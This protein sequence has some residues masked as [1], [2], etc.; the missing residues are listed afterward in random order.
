MKNIKKT[1]LC[2]AS[3]FFCTMAVSYGQGVGNLPLNLNF[4][5][6]T[7]VPVS[8]Q[9]D[10]FIRRWT[11]LEP[12]A[13]TFSS[14]AMLTS[15]FLSETLSEQYFKDQMTIVPVDGSK[16]T[17]GKTKLIWHALDSKNFYVNL[18]RFATAYG[19]ECFQ[20]LYWV[21]TIIDCDKD[22]ENVRLA[23]GVNSAAVWFLNDAEVL[24]FVGDKDLIVDDCM[25]ARLTLKQ[26]RNILRGIV[27]NGQGMADFC[28]RFV[29]EDGKP[30]TSGYT[31]SSMMSKKK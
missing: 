2:L 30:V 22:I 25:S 19:K 21:V 11:L 1:L 4:E 17:Y 8:P 6:A 31:V 26:G 7:A 3:I 12:I 27:M 13:R 29:D 9:N 28:L 15:D 5:P 18:L 23:G 16:A 20:Q 10:G 14:N 24:R